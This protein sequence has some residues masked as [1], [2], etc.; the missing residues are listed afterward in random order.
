MKDLKFILLALIHLVFLASSVQAHYDPNIGRWLSRDPI[1][2]RGGVNLLGFVGNDSL[3][4]T[5]YLGLDFIA[6]GSNP[7]LHTSLFDVPGF[8]HFSVSYWK[9]TKLCIREGATK[10][11][12]ASS[13]STNWMY[14]DSRV[15]G[16]ATGVPNDASISNVI[17]LDFKEDFATTYSKDGISA[18]IQEK[19]DVSRVVRSNSGNADHYKDAAEKW[20]AIRSAAINYVYAE[21]QPFVNGQPAKNWPNSHYGHLAADGNYNNSNTFIHVMAGSINRKVPLNGWGR[22]HPGNIVPAPV[23]GDSRPT[24]VYIGK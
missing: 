21:P 4:S 22:V 1:M 24:P 11:G 17:Q 16:G 2:E 18:R 19:V 7:A 12:S 23:T 14:D 8:G 15:R 5:D 10:N 9:E 3:N 20:E 6:V 13:S